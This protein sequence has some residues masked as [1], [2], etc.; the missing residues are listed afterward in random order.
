MNLRH[1]LESTPFSHTLVYVWIWVS[2]HGLRWNAQKVMD[3]EKG[4]GKGMGIT[5]LTLSSYDVIHDIMGG[6]AS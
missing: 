3:G 2:N 4:D 6:K 1:G 5:F